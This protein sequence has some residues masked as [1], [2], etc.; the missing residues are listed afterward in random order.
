MPRVAGLNIV[1]V[2]VA[3]IAIFMVG[4]LFYGVVFAQIWQQQFLENHGA[5]PLGQSGSLTGDALMSALAAVP[6]QMPMG[7]AMGAGFVVALL[8]A[9]GV[10]GLMKIARPKSL[11][12]ALQVTLLVWAGFTASILAYN[13]VYYAESRISLG[14]DIAHTLVAFLIGT[15]VVWFM[16][17]KAMAAG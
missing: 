11:G 6:G 8:E 7:P 9:A 15:L 3:A 12:V 2:L 17:R 5:V 10:A 14:I 4:F 16:D 13:V 1:A